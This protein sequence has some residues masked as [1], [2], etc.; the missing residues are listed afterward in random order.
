MSPVLFYSASQGASFGAIVALEWLGKPYCLCRIEVG[1][2]RQGPLPALPLP[3]HRAP[4][5]LPAH[6]EPINQGLAILLH[7]A[8]QG[9]GRRPGF[10]PGAPDFDRLSGM[11]AYLGADV[12][13]AFNPLWTAYERDDLTASQ[14]LVLK[15]LGRKDVAMHCAHLDRL[16]ADRDWLLGDARS[17]ADAE[18]AGLGRWIERFRL[19]ELRRDYPRLHR[20]LERLEGDPAVAFARA[21]EDGRPAASAGGF[22]GHVTLAELEPRLRAA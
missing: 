12:F 10:T 13:A 22:Q 11:L 17:V 20:H 6:G 16:L 14:T 15:L 5:L 21:V 9:A 2:A 4:T 7:L 18:L 3:R 1:E 8:A 19:F